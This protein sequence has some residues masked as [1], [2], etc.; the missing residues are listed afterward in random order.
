MTT[1]E[2]KRIQSFLYRFNRLDAQLR[3][4]VGLLRRDGTFNFVVRNYVR[5]NPNSIDVDLLYT[6]A[7]IRNALVHE[8]LGEADYPVVPTHSIIKQFDQLLEELVAP[9]RVIP[10]FRTK[11]D[12]VTPEQVLTSVLQLIKRRDF[13]QFPVYNNY[14]FAGLLTENGIT[15]WLAKAA[16]RPVPDFDGVRVIRLL[17]DEESDET[18]AFVAAAEEVQ[19]VRAMFANRALLEAVLITENGNSRPPLKGIITRWDMLR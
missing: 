15:R 8:A 18:C 17:R 13:S 2:R 4:K 16:G 1:D 9:L 14:K 6:L 3:R 19:T 10:T 5:A 11:V 12:T 7:G